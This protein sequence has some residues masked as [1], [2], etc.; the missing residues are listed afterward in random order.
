MGHKS[1]ESTFGLYNPIAYYLAAGAVAAS[2]WASNDVR[3]TI[4]EN[5]EWIC[6]AGVGTI[7]TALSM[8]IKGPKAALACMQMA[9]NALGTRK[10]SW[11]QYRKSLYAMQTHYVDERPHGRAKTIRR[12]EKRRPPQKQIV[13]EEESAESDEPEPIIV[14]RR[15]P[16]RKVPMLRL[17]DQK[18]EW[19]LEETEE[20][21]DASNQIMHIRGFGPAPLQAR[22][23]LSKASLQR[24]ISDGDEQWIVPV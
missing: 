21:H 5:R 7:A 1:G 4:A 3:M 20:S 15:R 24:M 2:P 19:D 22:R 12:R 10:E 9:A 13:Y 17:M 18:A 14:T 6:I 16:R 23:L 8:Y 11:D